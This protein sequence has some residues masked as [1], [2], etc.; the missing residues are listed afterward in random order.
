MPAEVP[1][2]HRGDVRRLEHRQGGHIVP[3]VEVTAI[4]GHPVERPEGQFQPGRHLLE[5]EDAQVVGAHRG[6]ELEP[7]VGWGGPHRDHRR[8]ILLKIVG[9]QP[10]GLRTHEAVEVSPVQ[11]GITI[12]LPP[13]GLGQRSQRPDPRGTQGRGREGR[14]EPGQEQRTRGDR[15]PPDLARVRERQQLGDHDRR[16]DEYGDEGRYHRAGGRPKAEAG[17]QFRGGGRL[18]FQEAPPGDEETPQRPD[19]RVSRNPSLMREKDDAESE[20]RG[21]ADGVQPDRRK[22]RPGRLRDGKPQHADQQRDDPRSGEGAEAKDGPPKRRPRKHRPPR[23]Q[24]KELGQL[25]R[26]APEVV[27]DLPPRQQREPIRLRAVRTRHFGGQPLEQLPVTPDPPVFPT[28]VGGIRRRVVVVDV[29]VRD[30]PGPGVVTLDQVMGEQPILGKP[31]MRRLLEDGDIV[32]PF[33][34]ETPF[35]I[36]IL[37]DVRHGGRIR[38][39]PGNA[40]VHGR[41]S[42]PVGARERHT[43]AGLQNPVAPNHPPAL[44]V[45]LGPIERMG[46]GP[47]QV[48]RG[49]GRQN[50]VRVE[51]NHIAKVPERRQVPHDDRERGF[52]PAPDEPVELGQL[53]AF[54]LPSHPAVLLRIPAPR[55][56]EEIE[57]IAG[58]GGVPGVERPDAVPSGGDDRVVPRTAFGGRIGEVAQDREVEMG[59]AVGQEPDLECFERR[60][61]CLEAAEHGG[62]HDGRP[63]LGRDPTPVEV[64]FRQHPRRQ[65]RGDQ[66]I[67]NAD[68]DVVG[69]QEADQHDDQPLRAMEPFSQPQQHPEREHRPRHDA[70]DERHVRMPVNQSPERLAAGLRIV[71]ESFERRQSL[72]DQVVTHVRASGPRRLVVS[73]P[74][75]RHRRPRHRLLGHPAPLGDSLH[76]MA[77]AIA[78]GERHP[79]VEP[80]RIAPEDRLGPAL[81]LD[82]RPPVEPRHR[83]EAGDTVGH[84]QLGQREPLDRLGRHGVGRD[85]VLSQPE[86]EPFEAGGHAGLRMEELEQPAGE[87]RCQ[88]RMVFD[89]VGEDGP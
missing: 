17:A 63:E 18:P 42:G 78:G 46:E 48:G 24:E 35:A 65:Q 30:Q 85:P 10:V 71:H 84:H 43:H 21:A 36:Q 15:E 3:V 64:E 76:H 40:G 60:M 52:G 45:I 51:R 28:A 75:Q 29:H 19:D 59:L 66:L 23:H 31:P 86:F 79:G 37:I 26:T 81:P 22:I 12:S 49:V 50:G 89:E 11:S 34:G 13:R 32:D 62:D 67:E 39:D 47:D 14:P 55:P 61:D 33:P 56:M 27:E 54:P 7:D 25:H 74:S 5:R 16:H 6:Q 4:S 8:R 57:G 69:R 72:V 88:R 1:T 83:P 53:A 9:R 58:V 68:R 80:G 2:V 38:I 87:C 20:L 82:E 44:G 41:E 77:I 70:P 73:H